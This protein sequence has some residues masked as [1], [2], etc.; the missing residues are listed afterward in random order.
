MP[1]VQTPEG[2]HA[3][4]THRL[5]VELHELLMKP[6]E[7]PRLLPPP[8]DGK[9]QT[10]PEPV[11]PQHPEL[12]NAADEDY[13]PANGRRTWSTKHIY[14]AMR[15]WAVPWIRS[16]VLAGEFH[17]IIAYLF[18]EWKCNLDCHYCWAFDNSV[19]GMT[20]DTA[21]RSIDWLRDSGAG[22]LAL[23]VKEEK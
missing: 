19:R 17:P 6:P 4:P 18:N 14:R 23:M 13:F 2:T 3:A 11:F 21:K 5:D 15:G 1:E 8:P 16:R 20:E 22:V 9:L 10:L 7:Q 12:M